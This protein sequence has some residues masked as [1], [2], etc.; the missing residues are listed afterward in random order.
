MG[1]NDNGLKQ[2]PW[3]APPVTAPDAQSGDQGTGGGFTSDPGA[4]GLS[5]V[6]WSGAPVPVPGNLTESGPFGNPSRFSSVDGGTHEG[7]SLQGDITA[8]PTH[9]IDKK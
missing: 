5:N 7:E 9:T 6:P 1:S 4:N 2:S 8:T 3:E